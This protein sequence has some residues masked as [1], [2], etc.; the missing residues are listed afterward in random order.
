MSR[1]ATKGHS[2]Q[3]AFP[4]PRPQRSRL[5]HLHREVAM[6]TLFNQAVAA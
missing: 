5:G 6:V 2:N 4:E 3:R 1:P